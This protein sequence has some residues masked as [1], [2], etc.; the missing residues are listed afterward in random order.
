MV[1]IAEEN[2][3]E[4]SELTSNSQGTHPTL[5]AESVNK[6]M[7]SVNRI[8]FNSLTATNTVEPAKPKY[9]SKSRSRSCPQF[10]KVAT[11]YEDD[12]DGEEDVVRSLSTDARGGET[13]PCKFEV[14]DMGPS[15]IKPIILDSFA[16]QPADPT[17]ISLIS[18]TST[19]VCVNVRQETTVTMTTTK[20]GDM[21]V[22]VVPQCPVFADRA[23]GSSHP[24]TAEER[25][26]L[27]VLRDV[28]NISAS[29]TCAKCKGKVT[30]NPQDHAEP[31]FLTYSPPELLDRHLQLGH[32]I[33]AKELS[34]IPI[35][36]TQ[37]VNWTHFGGMP[38]ADEISILRTQ[39]KLMHNQLMYERHRR[40]QHAKRNRRLLRHIANSKTLE[41]Q[42]NSMREQLQERDLRIRDLQVAY[43]QEYE[44]LKNAKKEFNTLLVR[45]REEQDALQKTSSYSNQFTT[46]YDWH[47]YLC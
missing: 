5:T 36:S 3:N 35:P 26:M 32:D 33:H 47:L 37:D 16:K 42:N 9:S 18:G 34:R 40:D 19:T 24:R 6:F 12:E 13:Q 31:F 44:D 25:S 45:Q 4:V 43:L 46:S 29:N 20:F 30:E 2:D 15:V 38:P 11:T 39:L 10:P 23:Q 7:K 1:Y 28:L 41:E 14:S 8:R 17:E 27:Q 22:G 21:G